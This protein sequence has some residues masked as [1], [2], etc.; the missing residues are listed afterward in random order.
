MGLCLCM[1]NLCCFGRHK[2]KCLKTQ[3]T[4]TKK[5]NCTK[6]LGCRAF[7]LCENVVRTFQWSLD[8]IMLTCGGPS[9]WRLPRSRY[10]V[11]V[12]LLILLRVSLLRWW[13]LLWSFLLTR[14]IQ[15]ENQQKSKRH[16]TKVTL[17]PLPLPITL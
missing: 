12:S 10:N 17:S 8:Q 11:A 9:S 2:I 15:L 3:L 7:T 1:L 4:F 5:C 14:C 16:C 13:F 6:I